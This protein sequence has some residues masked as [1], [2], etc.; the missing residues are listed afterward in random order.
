[1]NKAVRPGSPLAR[2]DNSHQPPRR[3]AMIGKM[4]WQGALA[5]LL[6]ASAAGLFQGMTS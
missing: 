3:E 2:Q 1:M 4:L 6:I 5:A